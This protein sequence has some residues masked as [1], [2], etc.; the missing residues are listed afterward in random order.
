MPDPPFPVADI[1]YEGRRRGGIDEATAL[2]HNVQTVGAGRTTI[3]E[4]EWSFADGALVVL[5][6][7][8]LVGAVLFDLLMQDP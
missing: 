8:L 2:A 5:N 3:E 1:T 6:I 4:V 7:G